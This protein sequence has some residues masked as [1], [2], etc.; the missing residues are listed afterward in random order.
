MHGLAQREGGITS[1][2]RY[3]KKIFNNEL[4]DLQSP[5]ICYGDADLYICFEPV[6]ALRRGIFASQK[7]SFVLNSRTIP[8]V[9]ITADLEQYPS[10]EKIEETL[11]GYSNEVYFMNV[12][13]L[14]LE[15]FNSN[16]QVNLIMLGFAIPT[17]KLP[18]IEIE[19]YEEVIKEWLRDPEENIQALHLGIE[20][21][22]E[23]I[24]RT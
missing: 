20:K 15:H 21:G 18:F 23:I 13:E 10:L 2:T 16:Q 4:K 24:S 11:K 6:E 1:H 22:K 7:T 19:H 14:S 8:G 5:L 3:Q 12:T 9:M 17:G